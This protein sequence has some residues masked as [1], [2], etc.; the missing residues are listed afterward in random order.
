MPSH[1][2]DIHTQL[3]PTTTY[4]E[5]GVA[6]ESLQASV[7]MGT[8][9][10]APGHFIENGKKII[11]FPLTTFISDA[12]CIDASNKKIID[13]NIVTTIPLQKNTTVL[14]FTGWDKNFYQ[15]NYFYDHPV[16]SEEC[17]RYLVEIG[18]KMIGVDF[19]SVDQEP[20]A[21]HKIFLGNDILIIENMTN[22]KPLIDR[23]F[24][25]IAL[26]LKIDAYGAP[27]RIIAEIKIIN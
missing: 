9:I 26:P 5:H 2:L 6:C 23:Q 16:I 15:S 10:D 4:K 11:D 12:I 13:K 27:A 14:F 18:I 1:P 25:L 21:I 8:H 7:H 17:A 22:L 19:P 3:T 24:N 20:Y